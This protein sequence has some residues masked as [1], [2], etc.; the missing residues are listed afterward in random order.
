[1]R[2]QNQGA[3]VM[4]WDAAVIGG[5]PAGAA[6]AAHLAQAGRSTVLFEKEKGAHDKV[7]GEFMSQEGAEYLAAL[8]L[9][10]R[11]LGSL[12]IGQVRLVRQGRALTRALPFEAQSLSRRVLDEALL[13][14]AAGAGAMIERGARVKSVM[15]KAGGWDVHIDDAG[16]VVAKDVFLA[17][18]KHDLKE[19]KR[20][21]GL[22]PGLI[23]FKTYWRLTPE[24]AAKLAGH[25]ELILFPGGYAGLQPVEGSRANLCLLVRRSTFTRKYGSWERLLGAMQKACPHLA[26]RLDG[27]ECLIEKPLAI[28]GLPYGH[29]ARESGG[30][31]RLGDQAV[32]IPSFSGDGMSIALHSANLA[33]ECYLSGEGAQAYQQRL[34]AHVARQV[35][36][37]TLLSRALASAGGQRL[38][39]AAAFCVPSVLALGAALTRIPARAIF[40]P[41]GIPA[42]NRSSAEASSMPPASY[43]AR[44]SN[45]SASSSKRR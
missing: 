28:A 16:A 14:R 20:P 6:L 13:Q 7:C 27:A 15:R 25:V 5:G 11:N 24:E 23:A 32:V 40:R 37:A 33:A 12:A 42:S 41:H 34:A 10:L 3:S 1:L 4:P 30:V 38:A 21:A 31:W 22:Q 36:R 29:V 8:G 18:G 2:I 44:L 17:T 45:S 19:W 39:V 35:R 9:S 26:A 43:R